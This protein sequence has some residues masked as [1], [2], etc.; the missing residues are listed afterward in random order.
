MV[1]VAW[2]RIGIVHEDL[3]HYEAA[4]R[5]DQESLKI[6]VSVGNRRGEA[7]TLLQLGNLYSRMGRPEEAVRFYRQAAEILVEV[8]DLKGEGTARSNLAD[9]FIKLRASTKR[10]SNSC[11]R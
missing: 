3:G 4:E 6:Q 10:A 7:S 1:A 8:G 2:H 11:E 9:E 5:A